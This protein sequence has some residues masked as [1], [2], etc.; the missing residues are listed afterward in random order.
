MTGLEPGTA[1]HVRAYATNSAGTSYGINVI[2]VADAVTPTV[3]TTAV[4]SAT[5]T[6]AISGGNVTDD[7]GISVTARGICW[8]TSSNPTIAG[9]H[10]VNGSGTGSFT[11]SMTSLEPGTAY[12]VRAYATSSAGTSYGSQAAFSTTTVSA[13]VTTATITGITSTTGTGG[14]NVTSDGGAAV[15]A[16]GVCW[17]TSTNPTTADSHTVDSNG[18]GSFTSALTD[19]EPGTA[20]FVRAYATNSTGTAYGSQVSFTT[21]TVLP[22]VVTTDTTALTS[23]TASGGGNVTANG[24][25]GIFARGIC[26]SIA[27][28]PTTAA[29]HTSNGT[30]TG[31]FS[32]SITGLTA[33][34]TYYVRAYATN[35]VGTAYGSQMSFTTPVTTTISGIVTDGANPV[36]GVN[37][38]FTHNEHV[39]VTDANGAYSYEVPQGATTRLVPQ[40]AGYHSW[41]PVDAAYTN[42]TSDQVQNFVGTAD[43]Y[44]VSGTAADGSTPL[45]GVEILF[46]HDGHIA[47]TDADGNYSYTVP[48]GTTF[49]T[50]ASKTGYDFTPAEFSYETLNQDKTWQNFYGSHMVAVSIVDPAEGE[51]VEDAVIVK[52]EATASN[53]DLEVTHVDF[54]IDGALVKQDLDSPYQYR[55]ETGETSDGNHTIKTIAYFTTGLTAEAQVT[56]YVANG[57][58][59]AHI[60]LNRTRLNYGFILEEQGTSAQTLLITNTGGGTLNWSAEVSDSWIQASALSGTGNSEISVSI[61]PTGLVIGDYQGTIVISAPETDNAPVTVDVYLVV[62]ELSGDLPLIGSIDTPEDSAIVAGGIAVT[63]WALDDSEVMD[64]QIFRNPVPGENGPVHLGSAVF[65]D[66]A[67]PDI[68]AQYPDYPKNYVAG[69]GYMV[70]T[71]TFPNDGNGTFTIMAVGTDNS[72]RSVTL[73]TRTIVCDNGNAVMP[74]GTIDTPE[75]GGE[76]SGENYANFGWTLTP[77]PNTIPMDGSTIKVVVDGVPLEGHVEYNI[78]REDNANAFPGYNNTGGA[79]GYYYLDTTVYANGLHTIAW[80]VTDDAGNS[81]GIGS[82]YFKIVNAE[83]D[84]AAP[85]YSSSGGMSTQSLGIS[86]SP[87]LVA[88]GLGGYVQTLLPNAAGII[89]VDIK[90]NER[91]EVNLRGQ[92]FAAAGSTF[93]TRFD[94]HLSQNDT[95]RMLPVGST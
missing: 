31:S 4:T 90:G 80:I 20:Y 63:G 21:T 79:M 44:T 17:S 8:G 54:Y 14:G 26:W 78:Y 82:R 23:T 2:F 65:V 16:R 81:A 59:P 92:D 53:A 67:R 34:A 3:T 56:A 57:M 38:I 86:S 49:T 46:S 89:N 87:V 43:N 95:K 64:V 50:T 42:I 7:G 5:S 58:E 24:G 12:Y 37:I 22:T 55:W 91:V 68:E 47:T 75:Q 29:D 51:V 27:A 19:L 88:K 94:A 76:A 13:A 85:T 39:E 45:A 33:G 48:H 66:G 84:T 69:W 61:D 6:S 15:T 9:T 71:Q 1:Y 74:F 30:G 73:G 35:A 72:G 83:N 60:E 93:T 52:A 32:S 36:E 28:N 10:T 70:L 18:T 25:I 62:K 11:G 40:K 41:N 77:R